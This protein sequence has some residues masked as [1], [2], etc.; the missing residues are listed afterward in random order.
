MEKTKGRLFLGRRQKT[1]AFD[2]KKD[3]V[4]PFLGRT[5]SPYAV[6]KVY[7]FFSLDNI[8]GKDGTLSVMFLILA[9]AEIG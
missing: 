5:L 7:C 4:L 8:F 2:L 3:E 9:V 6:L 1:K